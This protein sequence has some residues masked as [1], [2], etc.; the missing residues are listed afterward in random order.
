[1]TLTL[2]PPEGGKVDSGTNVR[3]LKQSY[4]KTPSETQ[5]KK[6]K[7]N[8]KKRHKENQYEFSLSTGMTMITF[9]L[10]V[11]VFTNAYVMFS[12]ILAEAER[13]SGVSPEIRLNALLV[14]ATLTFLIFV[15]WY[16][17]F[18]WGVLIRR[19]W[20]VFV[21]YLFAVIFTV[22]TMIASSIMNFNGLTNEITRPMYMLDAS[23]KASDRANDV[24]NAAAS[25]KA[26]LPSLKALEKDSCDLAKA[27]KKTGFASGTGRG[28]GAASSALT[29]A[30]SGVRALREE[31]SKSV[32]EASQKTAHVSAVIEN[33]LRKVDDRRIPLLDREDLFRDGMAELDSLLRSFRNEGLGKSVEAGIATL[34]NLV[35]SVDNASGIA[36]GARAVVNGLNTKLAGASKTLKEVLASQKT[37]MDYSPSQRASM[38]EISLK[39]VSHFPSHLAIA[40]FLDFFPLMMFTYRFLFAVKGKKNKLK[41]QD[42]KELFP[43]S[44][45]NIEELGE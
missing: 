35:A 20:A 9:A 27:E 22:F 6:K 31:L 16:I 41:K 34:Q 40:I 2:D 11:G 44:S 4:K 5:Q 7:E 17:I 12:G 32:A 37:L 24:T 1:M 45:K 28:F 19:S 42:S 38:T 26:A 39:Y 10:M 3:Y 36:G 30:C 29:S 13:S 25:A 14:T 33:L 21:G 15:S 23:Y 8:D 43:L 18:N